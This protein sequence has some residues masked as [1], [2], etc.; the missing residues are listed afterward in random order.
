MHKLIQELS[1]NELLWDFDAVSLDPSAMKYK[2][3]IYPR[4]ETRYAFTLD[5]K[6]ELVEIFDNQTFTQGSTSLKI[7]Y[8]IPK[9]LIVHL[10]IKERVKQMEINRMQKGYIVDVLTSVVIQEL[11]KIG[12][13]LIETYDGIIYWEDFKVSPFKKSN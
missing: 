2:K 5:M 7:I 3:S 4:I 12:G 11:I 6:D 13:K 8:H 1:L 9:N 10:P